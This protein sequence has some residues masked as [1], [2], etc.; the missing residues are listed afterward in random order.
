MAESSDSGTQDEPIMYSQKSY[1]VNSLDN[2]SWDVNSEIQNQ[3]YFEFSSKHRLKHSLDLPPGRGHLMNGLKNQIPDT[4]QSSCDKSYHK[5]DSISVPIYNNDSAHSLINSTSESLDQETSRNLSRGRNRRKP[6][7]SLSK[8]ELYEENV[9]DNFSNNT[10]PS[11]EMGDQG[12]SSLSD[13]NDS[14][15]HIRRSMQRIRPEY[16][17]VPADPSYIKPEFAQSFPDSSSK[18]RVY[19]QVPQQSNFTE[20]TCKQVPPD[21]SSLLGNEIEAESQKNQFE[22]KECYI[23]LSDF[24]LYTDHLMSHHSSHENSGINAQNM[25]IY[26]EDMLNS[27]AEMIKARTG[28]NEVN[29][30]QSDSCSMSGVSEGGLEIDLSP[31]LEDR[32]M[33]EGMKT[34]V[35]KEGGMEIKNFEGKVKG[36]R[37]RKKKTEQSLPD[38]NS[39]KCPVCSKGF[40]TRNNLKTHL[41]K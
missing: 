7:H 1:P 39:I 12:Q 33:G 23:T 2:A 19:V 25:G 29:Q 24:D 4:I 38:T 30:G 18:S 41:C 36:K 37:G 8:T 5:V 3:G 31:H 6:K 26:N 14:N 11:C 27:I 32:Q 9:D 28:G 20:P 16:V 15:F 35:N 22:C 21:A 40:K 13:E 17:Q 34:E 10:K